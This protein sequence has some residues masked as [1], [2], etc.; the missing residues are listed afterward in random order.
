M[1]RLPFFILTC[2]VASCSYQKSRQGRANNT[3]KRLEFIKQQ[4]AKLS[5]IP[6]PLNAEPLDSYCEDAPSTDK[7]ILGYRSDIKSDAAISFYTAEMERCG[8]QLVS[9]CYGL[10]SILNFDK[11]NRFC[12]ISIQS[13]AKQSDIKIVI[14]TGSKEV[15]YS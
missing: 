4:E 7:L 11:P 3:S 12:T 13:I 2:L 10:E 14:F 8:W 9:S 1:K 5:D 15:N 6:I